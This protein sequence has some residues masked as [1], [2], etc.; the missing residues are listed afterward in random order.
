MDDSG[1]AEDQAVV[2]RLL[3][4]LQAATD[5]GL[6]SLT[7]EAF[8]DRIDREA[9]MALLALAVRHFAWATREDQATLEADPELPARL[10]ATADE[11]EGSAALLVKVALLDAIRCLKALADYRA[12]H[13]AA[14]GS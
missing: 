13:S 9:A 2:D 8:D 4:E 3:A 5:E 14:P 12:K 10:T 11:F 7:C 6:L 1:S